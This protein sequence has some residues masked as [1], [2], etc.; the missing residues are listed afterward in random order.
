[1]EVTANRARMVKTS[2]EIFMFGR[3]KRAYNVRIEIKR[4]RVEKIVLIVKKKTTTMAFI[5]VGIVVA[6]SYLLS[7]PDSIISLL[8]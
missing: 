6:G 3:V 1:M 5:S 7:F 8:D 4:N 2:G